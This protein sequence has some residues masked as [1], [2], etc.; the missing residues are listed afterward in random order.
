MPYD[1]ET[2][3]T[4]FSLACLTVGT[5]AMI[6]RSYIQHKQKLHRAG[7][8]FVKDVK[9]GRG[10]TFHNEFRRT[11]TPKQEQ[12]HGRKTNAPASD[13]PAQQ[14]LSMRQWLN[15]VNHKL[16]EIPHVF[17]EGG[18]GTGKTTYTKTVLADREGLLFIIGVKPDDEWG[19]GYIYRSSERE[20]ALKALDNEVKR[21]LDEND[22]SGLTIVL[23]DFTRL[24][25]LNP[26]VVDIYK[27]V[28]D[29][30][31]SLRIRL[32]LIA[33]GRLVKALGASG[34]SDLH[35]HF[36][37]IRLNRAHEAILE[38]D[39][40]EYILDTSSV[41]ERAQAVP[42]ARFWQP[43]NTTPAPKVNQEDTTNKSALLRLLE[44]IPTDESRKDRESDDGKSPEVPEKSPRVETN[45]PAEESDAPLSDPIFS[46]EETAKIAVLIASG[47]GKTEIITSMS[48]YT[49]RKHKLYSDHYERIKTAISDVL[50]TPKQSTS[51]TIEESPSNGNHTQTDTTINTTR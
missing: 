1:A 18:T 23:D 31:R 39:E 26:I 50:T 4:I 49:G 7:N 10:F 12:S 40:E 36:V 47:K 17:I 13:T 44:D 3:V 24:V 48:G 2:A 42:T 22:K 9:T 35:E 28:A 25:A 27:N 34:E 29:I 37:F 41:K 16:D 51:E 11:E 32:I 46:V 14:T 20:D 5:L 19:Q 38:Y 15:L 6:V 8:Q 21:R 30:G 45:F 33:R 43:K